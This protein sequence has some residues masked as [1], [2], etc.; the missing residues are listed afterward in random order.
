MTEL[1]QKL[2]RAMERKGVVW[3]CLRPSAANSE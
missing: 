1:R 3:E 2:I